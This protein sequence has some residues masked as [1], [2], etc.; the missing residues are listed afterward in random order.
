MPRISGI[1]E[2]RDGD[3]TYSQTGSVE[4]HTV[5]ITAEV[6]SI[7]YL[8]CLFLNMILRK[9]KHRTATA[10]ILCLGVAVIGVEM[11]LLSYVL[12][13]TSVDP[14]WLTVVNMCSFFGYDFELMAFAVYVWT[15]VAEKEPVSQSFVRFIR[16]ACL[17][18]I[19][20]VTVGTVT[21]KLF[22]IEDG[23]F[24]TGPWYNLGGVMGFVILVSL[25]VFAVK[26]RKTAGSTPV[27]F[28]VI[29]FVITY[30]SIFVTLFTGIDSYMYV[31]MSLIM[32]LVYII[33]Q[34]GEIEQ[35]QLRERIM[36]ELSTTDVLT[37]L[38]NRRAFETALTEL[39]DASSVGVIFCDVNGLKTANDNLGH[40]AGDAL[41]LRFSE[42]L[43]EHFS[44]SDIFRISGDE[45]IVLRP[46]AGEDEFSSGVNRLRSAVA[47]QQDIASVGSALGSG[48]DALALVSAAEKD[49][50]SDKKSYY[51]R[52][53]LDRR[54][55]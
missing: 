14:F 7:F 39:S 10:F 44:P 32:L 34:T 1:P 18:D 47:G 28:V 50:Y 53:G 3:F 43:R 36:F 33:L 9:E 25:L 49:M 11:D 46:D 37:K 12:E 21:G 48:A 40:A 4:V 27:I 51:E 29:F 8:L 6:I 30:T 42:L 15:I 19:L 2:L 23:N 41:L 16:I 35:G 24:V 52:Y 20:F 13:S 31:C 26:K 38:N 17:I 5:I 22:R 54:R 55:T 45:F